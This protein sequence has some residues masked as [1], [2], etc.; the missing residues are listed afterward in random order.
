MLATTSRTSSTPK[1]HH[2]PSSTPLKRPSTHHCPFPPPP[3][4]KK[5]THRKKHVKP[6]KPRKA[7]R[8]LASTWRDSSTQTA[9]ASS[10]SSSF[11]VA[12]NNFRHVYLAVFEQLSWRTKEPVPSFF[13]EKNRVV[14]KKGYMAMAGGATKSENYAVLKYM[15]C[16][17]N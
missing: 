15:P 9:M 17:L 2:Q 12:D 16:K 3:K 6:R 10:V 1:T 13:L 8:Q 4:K 7:A 14:W 5:Q 11:C